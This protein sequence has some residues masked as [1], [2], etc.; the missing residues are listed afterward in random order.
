MQWTVATIGFGGTGEGGPPPISNPQRSTHINPTPPRG[1]GNALR[2]PG[3]NLYFGV[4]L[5]L[6]NCFTQPLMAARGEVI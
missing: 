4:A 1:G 6:E 5:A 2:W 3:E